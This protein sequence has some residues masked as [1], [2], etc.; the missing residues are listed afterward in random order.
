MSFVLDKLNEI[1]I[2][3]ANPAMENMVIAFYSTAAYIP[4][5]L[6]PL[7]LY[8]RFSTGRRGHSPVFLF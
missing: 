1:N 4:A 3:D 8:T 2:I 7:Y 5:Q 6:I